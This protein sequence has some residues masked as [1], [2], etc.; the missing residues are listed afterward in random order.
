VLGLEVYGRL[1]APFLLNLVADLLALM[2]TIQA[3]ALYGTDVNEH[4]LAAAVRLNET[5]T[6]RRVEPLHSTCRHVSLPFR[7]RASPA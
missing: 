6:L 7:N 5:I 3:C 2:E 1:L 4:V